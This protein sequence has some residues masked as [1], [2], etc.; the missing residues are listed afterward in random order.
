MVF[1]YILSETKSIDAKQFSE[2]VN[3]Y[4]PNI[5]TSV[6]IY[7]SVKIVDIHISVTIHKSGRQ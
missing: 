6:E 7:I 4:P 1:A 3:T 5:N 2:S